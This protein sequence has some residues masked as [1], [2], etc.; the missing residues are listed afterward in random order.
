[1]NIQDHDETLDIN[2]IMAEAAAKAGDLIMTKPQVAEIML[3]QLLKC[4]PEH[5]QGLQLLGLCKHR[6]GENAEA[7]EII[8][9]ALDL[10]PDNADNWNNIGLS[11]AGL[12]FSDKA[13]SCIKKAIELRPEQP[14]FRN[15][16]GL[17]Y[18]AL[19]DY[20]NAIKCLREAIEIDDQPQLWLNL[21]GVYGEMKDIDESEKCFEHVLRLDPE[22]ATAYVDL[23]FIYF[24]RND[25][26]KAFACSE[27]RF[28]HFSQLEY[29]WN[30]FDQTKRWTGQEDLNGKRI[31]IY[32]EQGLGDMIQF[33]RF[34]K[35]LKK[36]GAHV[37]VHCPESVDALVKRL[38]GVDATNNR[39]IVNNLGEEFAPYDYQISSMSLPYALGIEKIDG[40]PYLKPATTSFRDHMKE[41]YPG[42]FNV[43]IVWA[44]SAAHPNDRTRS[45]P[46]RYFKP[47]YDTPGVKLFS[48]QMD[49]R[50]RRYGVTYRTKNTEKAV[51]EKFQPGNDIVDYSEGC[52]DMKLVDLTKMIQSFDD[53]ATILAGLDL[54]ICCD[55]ATAHVA[56]AMGVPVWVAI[57]YNPDWRWLMEGD[58]TQWYDSMRLYRQEERDNWTPVFE[59]M[60]KDLH[61]L[62]LQNQR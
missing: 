12:G 48:L 28:W 31:L 9:T 26:K 20:E 7:V 24:L 8:Q 15:N 41:E 44:G 36:L 42:T 19:G 10:D 22:N 49:V 40:A 16:L 25:L 1:M 27:W 17:Q 2:A 4:D 6:M 38:D 59:R 35:E 21:G 50:R 53:T 52:E 5:F 23:S 58:T 56:G 37:T 13:I 43:G 30:S 18:R 32:G 51:N 60:Q 47:L 62:V 55:T 29:Y 14:A 45:I 34:V 39:D 11:Y 33:L 3:K 54:L 46:L 57:A 61:A